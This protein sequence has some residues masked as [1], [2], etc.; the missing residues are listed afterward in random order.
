MVLSV[1]DSKIS[2]TVISVSSLRIFLM[3][4]LGVPSLAKYTGARET[5]L[6]SLSDPGLGG[7]FLS[8]PA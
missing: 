4:N 8:I 1:F 5:M 6:R 3:I 2:E 7:N